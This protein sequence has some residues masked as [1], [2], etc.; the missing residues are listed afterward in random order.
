MKI[1]AGILAV[2]HA[3]AKK[4]GHFVQEA[5]AARIP[6]GGRITDAGFI[7]SPGFDDPGHYFNNLNCT[8]EIEIPGVR[9]FYIHPDFFELEGVSGCPYD[10]LTI[11]DETT[12][13]NYEFCGNQDADYIYTSNYIYTTAGYS[14]SDYI[15]S[16][17]ATTFGGTTTTTFGGTTTTTEQTTTT[18]TPTTASTTS[19]ALSSSARRKRRSHSSSYDSYYDDGSNYDSS[20]WG[21]SDSSFWDNGFYDPIFVV[22]NKATINFVTDYSVVLRGFK[23]RIEKGRPLVCE[24][25]QSGSGR[26]T[27]PFYQEPY[28]EDTTC[29]YYLNAEPGNII[30]INFESFDIQNSRDCGTNWLSING[31]KHC[32]DESKRH[33]SFGSKRIPPKSV[34][35][36]SDSTEVVFRSDGKARYKGFAFTWESVENPDGQITFGPLES[37]AAFHAHMESFYNQLVYQMKFRG[38]RPWKTD[39]LQRFWKSIILSE[40]F[41]QNEGDCEWGFHQPKYQSFDFSEF[42]ES[43]S[44][45]ENLASFAENARQF[46]D[47]FL[48]MDGVENP[49]STLIRLNH[50]ANKIAQLSQKLDDDC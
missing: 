33:L 9:D 7:V 8:W 5:G 4:N 14:T 13:A 49:R 42:D 45:C 48:C 34:L 30:K 36:H 11:I 2:A 39:G 18:T 40:D 29:R 47:N 26:I 3:K 27:S 32:G 44:K 41:F 31:R 35:I 20:Y 25:T 37:A 43:K 50:Q 17:D 12:N 38:S 1:S 46:F 22:G 28:K 6:C 10:S 15:S 23:L 24:E 19:L 16:T 21:G